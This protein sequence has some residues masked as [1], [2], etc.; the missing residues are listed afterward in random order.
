MSREEIA[1][2]IL[3][4]GCG[5]RD[6]IAAENSPN[7]Q[8]KGKHSCHHP[9]RH[10]PNLREG[11]GNEALPDEMKGQACSC[12]KAKG[13]KELGYFICDIQDIHC[14]C[15]EKRFRDQCG[16]RQDHDYHRKNYGERLLT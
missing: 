1:E 6:L 12:G 3:V 16:K 8:T 2:W 15:K 11:I 13:S 9:D 10:L 7:N 5:K 14:R 4:E